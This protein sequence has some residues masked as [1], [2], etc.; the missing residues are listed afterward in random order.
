MYH[1][2]NHQLVIEQKQVQKNYIKFNEEILMLRQELQERERSSEEDREARARLESQQRDMSSKTEQAKQAL[3]DALNQKKDLS[4]AKIGLEKQNSDLM[5]SLNTQTNATNQLK[6]QYTN[7]LK[8]NSSLERLNDDLREKN[9]NFLIQKDLLDNEIATVRT[10]L[11]HEKTANANLTG[12]VDELEASLQLGHMETSRLKDRENFHLNELSKL[13]SLMSQLEKEKSSLEHQLKNIEK[14]INQNDIFL[15]TGASNNGSSNE[16]DSFAGNGNGGAS[17]GSDLVNHVLKKF[18][19]E[20]KA[21]QLSEDKT[22]TLEKTIRMLNAD[23]TFLKDDLVKKEREFNEETSRYLSV[24]K[25]LDGELARK[26]QDA[27]ELHAE[28]SSLRIKEKHLNKISQEVKE[29]NVCLREECDR[30]RK[31][32]IETENFKVK[33]LQEEL[34][35][36]KTMNQLYRS[37]KLESEEEID[38]YRRDREKLRSDLNQLKKE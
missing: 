35:E 5:E 36:M 31:V 14:N 18:N 27:S 6:A 34:D 37:Q 32:S 23:L 28:I 1:D 17:A 8:I 33:K 11:D 21:R 9:N 29:E 3:V 24:K 22:F 26:S 12:R 25:E 7:L 19:D 20:R 30:L 15:A 13:K 2:E 10:A 16:V 4:E 38:S